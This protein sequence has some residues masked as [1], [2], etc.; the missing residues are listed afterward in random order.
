MRSEFAFA[1]SLHLQTSKIDNMVFFLN[2]NRFDGSFTFNDNKHS[3]N[4]LI[5]IYKG[6][7]DS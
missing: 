7:N 2:K 1:Q 5:L 3:F 6:R 4:I